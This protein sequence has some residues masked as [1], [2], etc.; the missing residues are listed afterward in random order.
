L[1]I[2]QHWLITLPECE[3]KHEAL[4]TLWDATELACVAAVS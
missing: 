3:E 4:K 1:A 2:A